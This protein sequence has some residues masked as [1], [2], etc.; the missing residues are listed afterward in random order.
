MQIL[1]KVQYDGTNYS[2]FQR[3]KN[4][5]TVQEKLEDAL[6]LVLGC[7]ITVTAASRTDAGVHAL[8]QM[9]CFYAKKTLV[10][11]AKLPHVINAHLP[12]DISVVGSREVPESFNP[13]FDAKYK[14]YTYNFFCASFPNPLKNRHSV[15][16][17]GQLDIESMSVA[18]GFFIGK[19]DF[20]AFCAT[21]SS[22]KTTVREVYACKCEAFHD[23]T[24]TM[25]I[26]GS[27][28]LYNMVRIIAGTLYYVGIGK[29]P[30]FSLPE[31]ILSGQRTR[32]GKTMPPR[33]LILVEVGY[34]GCQNV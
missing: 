23:G 10:P 19:H 1:L 13:R 15:F 3:Q 31:I 12:P 18:A 11:I 16:V 34:S 29:I 9:V 32:A 30:T 20:A 28:F 4:A 26:T 21:G 24:V 22:Q 27:G 8:G 6:T 33:G 14:T 17:P 25:T 7:K 2:G 5:L